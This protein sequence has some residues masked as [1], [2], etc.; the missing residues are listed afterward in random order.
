MKRIYKMALAGFAAAALAAS[1]GGKRGSR[2]LTKSAEASP[3]QIQPSTKNVSAEI[4]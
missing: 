3:M 1:L 2:C 4:V